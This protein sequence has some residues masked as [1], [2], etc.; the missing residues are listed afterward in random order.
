MEMF[1][2]TL[3][4]VLDKKTSSR[5]ADVV[6]L[7]AADVVAEI[8]DGGELELAAAAGEIALASVGEVVRKVTLGAKKRLGGG[9]TR[10]GS[11]VTSEGPGRAEHLPTKQARKVHLGVGLFAVLAVLLGGRRLEGVR[12]VRRCDERL[13]IGRRG[14]DSRE[15]EG[16]GR[17]GLV[18]HRVCP[19]QV[20]QD[21]LGEQTEETGLDSFPRRGLAMTKVGNAPQLEVDDLVLVGVLDPLRVEPIRVAAD[22]RREVRHETPNEAKHTSR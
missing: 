14:K 17:R 8:R 18:Q 15:E 13:V 9:G 3:D 22:H 2:L 20:H 4:R 21:R 5:R 11:A 7:A 12:A 16:D 10:R 19:E 1:G 6:D